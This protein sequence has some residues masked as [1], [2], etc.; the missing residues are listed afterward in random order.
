MDADVD[1][2][3]IATE[4]DKAIDVFHLTAAG[5]S[6]PTELQLALAEDLE[7]MLEAE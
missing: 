4:G 6:W 7:R 2:V 5:P 3:L 1:L